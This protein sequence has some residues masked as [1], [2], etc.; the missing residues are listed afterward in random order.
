MRPFRQALD[1]AACVL[2]LAL[3]SSTAR[4]QTPYPVKALL[5]ITSPNNSLTQYTGVLLPG[6]QITDFNYAG[7]HLIVGVRLKLQVWFSDQPKNPL[8]ETYNQG[9]TVFSCSPLSN[10]LSGNSFVLSPNDTGQTV[11]FIGTFTDPLSGKTVSN[12]LT[13]KEALFRSPG[14]YNAGPA[15]KQLYQSLDDL[16]QTLT[17]WATR[18]G[19]PTSSLGPAFGNLDQLRL[20]LRIWWPGKTL[21]PL[22]GLGDALLNLHPSPDVLMGLTKTANR[23]RDAGLISITITSDRGALIDLAAYPFPTW[24]PPVDVFEGIAPIIAVYWY[25]LG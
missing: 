18:T 8:D 6:G 13:I 20:Y 25:G 1:V 11:T 19:V 9:A 14:S 7:V 10:R 21:D 3:G 5:S 23:M 17:N 22:L 4:A 15:Q 24:L 16:S 2:A 12:T